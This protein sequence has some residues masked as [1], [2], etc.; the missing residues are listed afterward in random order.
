MPRLSTRA[1][2]VAAQVGRD[3][4]ETFADCSQLVTPR[5]PAFRKAMQQQHQTLAAPTALRVMKTH[6]V[7]LCIIM[8]HAGNEAVG[9]S[10][11]KKTVTSDELKRRE[12]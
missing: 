8:A 2:G 7:Q 11:H 1:Q 6:P 4:M 10:I 3:D 9:F 12:S 5:V